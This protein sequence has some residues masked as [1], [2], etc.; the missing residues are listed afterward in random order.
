MNA[1]MF[2][3]YNNHTACIQCLITEY[4]AD[5][6]A[7]DQVSATYSNPCIYMHL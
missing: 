4:Y 1:L 6:Y 3:A 5:V 7:V 2:A